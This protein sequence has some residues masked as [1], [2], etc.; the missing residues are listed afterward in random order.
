MLSPISATLSRGFLFWYRHVRF[1]SSSKL[2]YQS[3]KV[4]FK[5]LLLNFN[6]CFELC[7]LRF[8]LLPYYTHLP[9]FC[10]RRKHK[11]PRYTTARGWVDGLQEVLVLFALFSQ[12]DMSC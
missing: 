7:V 2:K 3:A 5:Y 9:I 6:F 10:N 11:A 12:L 1:R 8:E 4:K